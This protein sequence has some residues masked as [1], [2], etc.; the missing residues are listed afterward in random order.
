MSIEALGEI[1]RSLLTPIIA[2]VATYIAWQQW[3]TNQQ[4]LNLDRYQRRLHVYE[5]VKKLL[6]IVMRDAKANTDDL[7]KFRIATSEA[8]FLF[9]PDI[10]TYLDEIYRHG[11]NLRQWSQQY[12]DFTQETPEGYDHNKIVDEEHKELLWLVSQFDPAKLKFKKYLDI[13]R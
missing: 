9:G 13:S 3:K 1:S 2:V 4:K 5:E 11:L 7:L 10:T 8:D 12:R 6:S